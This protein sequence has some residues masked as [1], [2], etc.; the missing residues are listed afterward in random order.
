MSGLAL[1]VG[2][3]GH[4]VDRDGARAIAAAGRGRA[5]RAIREVHTQGDKHKVEETPF[6][7]WVPEEIQLQAQALTEQEAAMILGHFVPAV[8]QWN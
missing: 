3:D 6:P 1:W 2:R 7:H 4:P 8:L 5:S